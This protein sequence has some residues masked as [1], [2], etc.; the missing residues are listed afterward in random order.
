M[1]MAH[2]GVLLRNT[3]FVKP[4][5]H[6]NRPSIIRGAWAEVRKPKR[7]RISGGKN[8]PQIHSVRMFTT[9]ARVTEE[10]STVSNLELERL[11][12][13]NKIAQRDS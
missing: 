8:P 12:E 9:E 5:L 4:N 1:I 13:E 11:K 3:L 7:P 10:K 2:V 6:A